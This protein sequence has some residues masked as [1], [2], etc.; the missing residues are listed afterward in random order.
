MPNVM[1]REFPYTP[2]G[3][4]AARQYSQA[5]GMR[6]GGSMGFRP[7]GYANGGAAG[8]EVPTDVQFIFDGL[9]AATR[10]SVQD[11]ASYI[12][13]NNRDLSAML[14]GDMLP[15]GQA[16]FLR[17]TINSV[18]PEQRSDLSSAEGFLGGIAP[19]QVGNVGRIGSSFAEPKLSDA[20]LGVLRQQNPDFPGVV[21]KE[22]GPG[23]D[24]YPPT[25][26]YNGGLM[27]LGRR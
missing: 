26:M 17:N 15:P 27:S 14:E 9:V 18:A 5:M 2:Q 23:Y 25:G 6:D 24:Y 21:P 4:A 10:G 11:V 7:V 12:E 20:D 8:S 3:M 1:G 22:S 19:G 13:S 16:N